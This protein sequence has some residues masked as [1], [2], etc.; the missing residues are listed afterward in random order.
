MKIKVKQPYLGG[1]SVFLVSLLVIGITVLIV[2][3]TGI[4]QNRTIT[5]NFD[6][7]LTIIGTALFLFMT[8]GLFKG[9]GLKDDFPKFRGYSEG[10]YFTHPAVDFDTP[11]ISVDDGIGG[12]M[13]SILLWIG[14]S[15]LLVLLMLVLEIVFWFS[16]FILLAMLYWVFFRAL[17]LVFSKS[18]ETMGDLGVSALYSFGYT[19]LYIGWMFGIVYL[20]QLLK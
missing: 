7:S 14:M 15:I 18:K 19:L 2:Y 10:D 4:N 5:D 8:Y 20:T 12:L 6:L 17:K 1:K 13:L 9:F 11:E 16:V 3:F